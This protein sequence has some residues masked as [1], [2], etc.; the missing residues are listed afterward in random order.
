MKL[1]S[2][3]ALQDLGLQE[4]SKSL[5]AGT[6]SRQMHVLYPPGFLTDLVVSTVVQQSFENV[7][8]QQQRQ[9]VLA[10]RVLTVAAEDVPKLL[11][12]E[13]CIAASRRSIED[14]TSFSSLG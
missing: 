7:Q 12:L 5:A 3:V 6:V 10:Q 13:E 14:R 9:A 2:V 1:D 11:H 4:Q 8:Q